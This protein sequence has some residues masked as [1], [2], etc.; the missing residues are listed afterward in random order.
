MPVQR[1]V[2]ADADANAVLLDVTNDEFLVYK[3]TARGAMAQFTIKDSNTGATVMSPQKF[4]TEDPPGTFKRKCPQPGDPIQDDTTHTL[5]L[6][7]TLTPQYSY[8]V[9]HHRVD[10]SV[11]VL[12]NIDYTGIP[13]DSFFEPLAIRTV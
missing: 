10:D 6:E 13:G 4:D 1:T 12:K 11:V 2:H 5:G 3:V 8:I 9:E 7:F